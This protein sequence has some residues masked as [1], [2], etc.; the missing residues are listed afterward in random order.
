VTVGKKAF[1]SKRFKK[2]EEAAAARKQ[3]ECLHWGEV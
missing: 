2:I 3:L 1:Y